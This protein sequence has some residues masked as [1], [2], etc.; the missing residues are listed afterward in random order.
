MPDSTA[1]WSPSRAPMSTYRRR[2]PG[3]AEPIERGLT[4]V[5]VWAPRARRVQVVTNAVA[6]ATAIAETNAVGDD[7]LRAVP[8]IT[9]E[10]EAGGYHSGTIKAGLGDRYQFKL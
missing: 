7:G 6:R 9:L 8:S 2:L 10:P 4:H 5:R 1:T 3:G